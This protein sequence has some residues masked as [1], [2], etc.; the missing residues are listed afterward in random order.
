MAEQH[1][2][3]AQSTVP[4]GHGHLVDRGRRRCDAASAAACSCRS[5]LR[6]HRSS[7]SATARSRRSPLL[8][9]PPGGTPRGV[10]LDPGLVER[11]PPP[12][13][14][15]CSRA[16]RGRRRGVPGAVAGTASSHRGSGAP[17]VPTATRRSPAGRS[18]RPGR[19]APRSHGG[20]ATSSSPR[21]RR[22]AS[23]S[24]FASESPVSRQVHVRVDESGHDRRA[25]QVDDSV[26]GGRVADADTL[27]VAAVDRAATRRSAGRPGYGRAPAR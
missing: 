12:R 5:W 3:V 6:G 1:S 14:R 24:A 17:V 18:E 23:T 27:H 20:A 25:R 19:P 16:R 10:A 15:R 26:G 2:E 4:A 11:L 7:S 9:Q 22:A 8:R 13:A 21:P